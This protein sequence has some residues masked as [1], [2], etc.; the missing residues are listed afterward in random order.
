MWRTS[1]TKPPGWTANHSLTTNYS[2]RKPV[3]ARPNICRSSILIPNRT[4]PP[5]HIEGIW[6]DELATT[7][8]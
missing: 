3:F 7:A 8:R 2:R 6:V 5:D 4:T 1:V